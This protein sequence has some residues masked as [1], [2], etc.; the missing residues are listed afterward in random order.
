MK[1]VQPVFVIGFIGPR[2]ASSLDMT[3]YR[4]LAAE[5]GHGVVPAVVPGPAVAGVVLGEVLGLP[6]VASVPLLDQRSGQPLGVGG[7]GIGQLGYAEDLEE[8]VVGERGGGFGRPAAVLQSTERRSSEAG[9]SL[10]EGKLA[11]HLV[12]A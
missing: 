1:V 8:L 11:V 5:Q 4:L 9:E 3:I 12:E 2:G 7:L 10:T 6:D